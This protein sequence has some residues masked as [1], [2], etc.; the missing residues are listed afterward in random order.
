MKVK[1]L[2]NDNLSLQ[3]RFE[4]KADAQAVERWNEKVDLQGATPYSSED[5]RTEDS[6]SKYAVHVILYDS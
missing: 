4:L 2:E 6:C 1:A 3:A 5:C